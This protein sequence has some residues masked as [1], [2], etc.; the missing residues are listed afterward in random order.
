MELIGKISN[1]M[2]KVFRDLTL[3]G[4]GNPLYDGQF[5]F[6][7]GSSQHFPYK[8]L[9]SGEKGAFDILLDL[10]IKTQ[11]FNKTVIGIDEPELHMHSGLQRSLLKEIYELIPSECQLWLAT[12]SI[13]FIR[14]SVELLRQHPGKV[15]LLDFTSLDFDQPQILKPIVP[16]PLKIREIFSVAIDDLSDMVVPSRIVICE[17]SL[18]VLADA[19]KKEFDARIYN[20]I[21][22]TEDVLFISGNS[23]TTAQKSAELLFKI[24]AQAGSIRG[25]SS[26]VDRDDLTLEKIKAFQQTN[27]SQKFLGRKT[28]ENYLLDSEIIDKYC[29][30]N[31]LDKTKITSRLIDPINEDAKAKQSAIMQQ[32]GFK[33]NTDD[34]KIELAKYITPDTATFTQLKKDIGI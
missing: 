2:K 29:D 26:I 4:T 24:V 13:G 10:L 17:G 3:E 22:S 27:P 15:V 19:A 31:G 12:H 11:D 8:N 21:F 20:S 30:L 33:G 28:I 14:G 32:C 34:F 18:A 1:A 23:K 5:Y 16:T 9:S 6:T 25:I 7:K